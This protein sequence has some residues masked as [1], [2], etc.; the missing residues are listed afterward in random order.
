MSLDIHQVRTTY[1][2]RLELSKLNVSKGEICAAYTAGF[3]TAEQ[4]IL[5]A[6]YRGYACS[7]L[8]LHGAMLAVGCSDQEA[9]MAIQAL[10]LTEII[11]VA[12]INSPKNVTLSGDRAGITQL[13]SHFTALD[14]FARELK[15]DGKAYHSKHMV[16]VGQDYEDILIAATE[17]CSVA[18]ESKQPARWISTVTGDYQDAY[19]GLRYWRDNLESP[20]L[21]SKAIGG[22]LE[23]SDVHFIEVGPHPVLDLPIQQIVA[24]LKV[25]RSRS[26]YSS[27]L[28]RGHSGV[29]CILKL[30]GHLYLRDHDISFP[31]VNSME[32]PLSTSA[33]YQ[34]QGKAMA[35]LPNY[36]WKY[37]VPLWR[38]SRYS[39]EFCGREYP[40]HDILGSRLPGMGETV[41]IW[42]NILRARDVAWLKDHRV[43]GQIV[44][45]AAGYI[46][47]AIEAAC[48]LIHGKSSSLPACH[49]EN[50]AIIKALVFSEEESAPDLEL[51]T[52]LRPI[53]PSSR[54]NLPKMWHFSI[55]SS[56]TAASI[57]HAEG[58]IGF[59][60]GTQDSRKKLSVQSDDL[61]R[62]SAQNWYDRMSQAGLNL[63]GDFRALYEVYNARKRQSQYTVATIPFNQP[64]ESAF[65]STYAL[66]PSTMD[67]ILHAGLIATAAGIIKDF[68]L[69]LPVSIGSM[70]I[71][72]PTDLA[73]DEM[74]VIHAYAEP[75]GMDS[76]K[77]SLEV[78][79]QHHETFLEIENC[80][81]KVPFHNQRISAPE[82]HP[83]LRVAWKADINRLDGTTSS[84]FASLTGSPPFNPALHENANFTRLV[85]VLDLLVHK[86]PGLRI[87]N[88]QHHDVHNHKVLLQYLQ[89]NTA[90]K[91]CQSFARATDWDERGMYVEK[92]SVTSTGD[93]DFGKSSAAK[94][95]SYDLL[96]Y[97][98]VSNH[99]SV[100]EMLI[101]TYNP[102]QYSEFDLP[103]D[104]IKRVLVPAGT[105]VG[106]LNTS[107]INALNEGGFSITYLDGSTL[108]ATILARRV[109]AAVGNEA[110]SLNL[111][112]NEGGNR[113]IVLVSVMKAGSL[114]DG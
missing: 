22:I 101:E 79:S 94:A 114:A 51:H 15:T 103:L 13:R 110:I 34:S 12:C 70:R 48:Q 111:T 86:S 3:I 32:L 55:S 72:L 88:V 47:M 17:S 75:V 71:A 16:T 59:E 92:A 102:L 108:P 50:I 6:Y 8:T 81:L 84:S 36:R 93:Y 61:E 20:V 9:M 7:G 24:S 58:E 89:Y 60:L 38:E 29:D 74:L 42:R 106:N 77:S 100:L 1:R 26:Q 109:E 83:I 73:A 98:G 45:P 97:S 23:E 66:H 5:I 107:Q 78:H 104:H 65:Q 39:S 87:L 28:T 25:D 68:Q 82:R 52:M 43:D 21:F 54:K 62:Q 27:T 91:R 4:A 40:R 11:Q 64:R 113:E 30:I 44:F 80:R 67:G 63:S 33:E 41:A 57:M 99:Q 2:S 56:P 18:P 96:L 69:R 19:D 90:F 95:A 37:E 46:A 76:M 10:N 53:L 31:R 85:T 49:L 105:L 35:N 112:D 14:I